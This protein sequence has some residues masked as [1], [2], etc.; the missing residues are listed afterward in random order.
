MHWNPCIGTRALGTRTFEKRVFGVALAL[1]HGAATAAM[2]H[3]LTGVYQTWLNELRNILRPEQQVVG[4]F[5]VLLEL[6]FDSC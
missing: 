2:T 4:L 6:F 1:R 3:S 5:G